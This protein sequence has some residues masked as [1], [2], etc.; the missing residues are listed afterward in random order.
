MVWFR[1]DELYIDR[2]NRFDT[3]LPEETFVHQALA[4]L[5]RANSYQTPRLMQIVENDSK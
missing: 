5:E 2:G 4:K 3:S 1:S